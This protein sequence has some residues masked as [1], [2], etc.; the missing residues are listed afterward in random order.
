MGSRRGGNLSPR[1]H[2]SCPT[3]ARPTLR[4]VAPSRMF[5]RTFTSTPSRRWKS[6]KAQRRLEFR[7]TS[8][9]PTERG[10]PRHVAGNGSRNFRRRSPRNHLPRQ[11]HDRAVAATL[12]KPPIS[13]GIRTT[14]TI[15]FGHVDRLPAL[16]AASFA[17][18]ATCK[19]APAGLTEFVPLPF[20]PMESA[21]SL[22]RR[23]S[24]RADLPRSRSDARG[25]AARAASAR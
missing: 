3:T 16:G 25:R 21:D 23:Q 15:M 1:R 14:A 18:S 22:A 10:R 11:D 5:A 8:F 9:W 13:L 2:P 19:A 17:A 7:F 12:S 6:G 24:P 20:V 4:F